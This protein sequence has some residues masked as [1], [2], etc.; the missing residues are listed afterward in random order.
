[1]LLHIDRELAAQVQAA[2]CPCGSVLHSAN[3][4]RKPR[5]CAPADRDDFSSRLSFCCGHCRRRS[6]SMSV[7][8]LGRRVYVM[9]A[10]VLCSSR[11]VERISA[12]GPL[13]ALLN[14]PR[15]TLARWRDWWT[16]LFPQTALWRAAGTRVMPPPDL[17]ALPD[18]LLAAF[19]GPPA[20]ALL[21]LLVFISPLTT[22]C[23]VTLHQ[24][25]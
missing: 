23:P 24:G 12:A 2:G 8:F 16:E 20:A 22:R 13:G 4:P 5:G 7:R 10:V 18:S 14:V 25:R 9:L 3:Y 17:Q 21:R 11:S 6:T 15:R 19:P 1:V